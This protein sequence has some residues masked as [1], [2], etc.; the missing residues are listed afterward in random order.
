MYVLCEN[1]LRCA[2]S[3]CLSVS[4]KDA[5]WIQEKAEQPDVDRKAK[6]A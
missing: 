5:W 2:H 3:P 1:D 6:G 4:Q